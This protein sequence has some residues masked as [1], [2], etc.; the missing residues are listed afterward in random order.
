MVSIDVVVEHLPA[1]NFNGRKGARQQIGVVP[2]SWSW[3]PFKFDRCMSHCLW[4]S[5]PIVWSAPVLFRCVERKNY[6]VG[7]IWYL[8]VTTGRSIID[9]IGK[10]IYLK[11]ISTSSQFKIYDIYFGMR[12]RRPI[13]E[14]LMIPSYSLK[15]MRNLPTCGHVKSSQRDPS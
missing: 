1:R 15:G 5:C 4:D 11:Y 14:I 9:S 6:L 12:K 7:T 2:W 10:H 13:A 8:I 3:F